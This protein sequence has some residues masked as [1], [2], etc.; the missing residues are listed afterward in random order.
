MTSAGAEGGTGRGSPEEAPAQP[1]EVRKLSLGEVVRL[2]KRTGIGRAGRGGENA[3]QGK[4]TACAKA[5]WCE[6]A[7]T[8]RAKVREAIVRMK[9]V[10][11]CEH[12]CVCLCVVSDSRQV[13]KQSSLM[14]DLRY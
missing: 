1:G 12:V 14:K 6:M 2:W 10:R 3:H 4:G 5:L 9:G 13:G 11:V 8:Q 7:C